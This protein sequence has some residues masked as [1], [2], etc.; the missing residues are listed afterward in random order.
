MEPAESLSTCQAGADASAV[1]CAVAGTG[2]VHHLFEAQVFG[3][4]C[5]TESLPV[6][7]CRQQE[8]QSLH[9]AMFNLK[10]CLNRETFSSLV[11]INIEY[12]LFGLLWLVFHNDA[13][14]M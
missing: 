13:L 9:S 1:D 4:G 10:A 6:R 5:T 12:N 8:Q 7:Q 2:L 11:R 3:V 14:R